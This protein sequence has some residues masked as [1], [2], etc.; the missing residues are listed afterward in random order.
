MLTELVCPDGDKILLAA[1]QDTCRLRHRCLTLPTIMKVTHERVPVYDGLGRLQLSTTALLNGTMYEYL[2]HRHD[3]SINPK[4]RA[5]ALLGSDHHQALE[6][7][8]HLLDL[9]AEESLTEDDRNMFDLL[10]QEGLDE[11]MRPVYVLTD[12][13]T[14]GSFK[15]AKT[16]GI[17]ADGPGAKVYYT[18]SYGKQRYRTQKSFVTRKENADAFELEMQMNRYRIMLEAKHNISVARMQVQITVR[19]GGLQMAR[20]RGVDEL[21]YNEFVD[22]VPDVDVNQYF[23]DKQQQ[24]NA[25]FD[26]G[27]PTICN[28]RERWDDMRCRGYCEIVEH[29]WHGRTVRES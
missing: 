23:H 28:P 4:S 10:E 13:K 24:M 7:W 17:V 9:Q 11:H 26:T 21:M 19:D 18:D 6:R 5:F 25:A 1:C 3:Y 8:A 20:Q 16:F 27:E 14:W 22:F 2:K 15:V 12:Y 29:C